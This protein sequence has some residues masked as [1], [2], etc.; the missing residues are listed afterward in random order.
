MERTGR[1]L[2]LYVGEFSIDLS[3]DF[4][5]LTVNLHQYDTNTISGNRAVIAYDILVI[6]TSINGG[7]NTYRLVS[8]FERDLG[9]LIDRG[10][11]TL[12]SYVGDAGLSCVV[13]AVG[14]AIQ[15][16]ATSDQESSWRVTGYVSV[17]GYTF[18]EA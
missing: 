16:N 5:A 1:L 17:R 7:V 9:T 11:V 3:H 14:D 2:R 6:A 4:G 13:E 8:T 12:S 10:T 18:A 15:I